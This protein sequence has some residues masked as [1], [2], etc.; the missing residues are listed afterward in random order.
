MD[1]LLPHIYIYIYVLLIYSGVEIKVL[2]TRY[3]EQ[4]KPVVHSRLFSVGCCLAHMAFTSTAMVIT[5]GV[6]TIWS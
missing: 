5:Q 4:N 6:I 1:D 3:V 2:C